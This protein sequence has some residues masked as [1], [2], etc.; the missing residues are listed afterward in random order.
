MSAQGFTSRTPVASK[1]ATSH[2]T[3]VIPCTTAVASIGASRSARGPDA[4]SR[5]GQRDCGIDRQDARPGPGQ[6]M[7]VHPAPEPAAP[8]GA[9]PQ[10]AQYADLQFH[11]GQRGKEEAR[12][13]LGRNPRRNTGVDP[14]VAGLAEL[15][16]DIRVQQEHQASS[17]G[18]LSMRARGLEVDISQSRHRERIQQ[19]AAP[20]RQ[21][22]VI[23]DAEQDI[24]EPGDPAG[25]SELIERL[26]RA[27]T[28][29]GILKEFSPVRYIP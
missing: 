21:P 8:F 16:D 13:I 29:Q 20:A 7:A 27:A 3:T 28:R 9:A 10:D 15:R 18:G 17:A 4:Q 23:P 6:H 26:L 22:P 19:A 11:E 24:C 12:R 14:A 5:A 1:P 25:L 2:V